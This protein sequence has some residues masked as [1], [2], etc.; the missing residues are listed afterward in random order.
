MFENRKLCF[1]T[2]LLKRIIV[3]YNNISEQPLSRDGLIAKFQNQVY[4]SASKPIKNNS[5][6]I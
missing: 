2:S 1:N 5:E 3:P 4:G 6:R